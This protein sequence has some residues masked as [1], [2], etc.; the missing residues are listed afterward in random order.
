MRS[1]L[2]FR[3]RRGNSSTELGD[4]APGKRVD[5][6]SLAARLTQTAPDPA[7][8]TFYEDVT[9]EILPAAWRMGTEPLDTRPPAR[10]VGEAAERVHDVIARTIETTVGSAKRVAVLASGGLDSSTV[11]SLTQEIMQRRGGSVF[12]VAI[13]FGGPGDDR[14]HMEALAAH[15]RCE[16]IRVSPTDG[17]EHL[18]PI[19]T[20]IDAAP[21]LWPFSSVQLELFRRARA[22][23]A[24]CVLT[25]VGGDDYFD[26]DP[27]SFGALAR[28][29]PLEAIRRARAVEGW[30]ERRPVLEY[31]VRPHVARLVPRWLRRLRAHRSK[32]WASSAPWAGPRMLDAARRQA[33][34]YLERTL[35]CRRA[36][37]LEYLEL[38]HQ[39]QYALLV[40]QEQRATRLDRYDPLLTAEVAATVATIPPHLLLAGDRWK[41]LLRVAMAGKL[42]PSLLERMDKADFTPAFPPFFRAIG[43]F[44]RFAEELEGKMLARLG[45][46]R[47]DVFG[48][49]VRRAIESP[50]EDGAYGLAWSALAAEAFL[51]RHPEVM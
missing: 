23:G 45:I 31:I 51:C 9:A 2:R 24:E 38:P 47:R 30:G 4:L 5:A 42:P 48:R 25:G 29:Q 12:A 22:A 28:T 46:V 11:L 19:W 8:R 35:A 27:H 21:M 34:W 7:S 33:E 18:E 49:E 44:E 39:T 43:G 1:L 17:A 3:D 20:G 40:H 37:P 15:L 26:G 6:A 14:P 36:S 32:G 10:T 41:G 16:V 50:D 13:D